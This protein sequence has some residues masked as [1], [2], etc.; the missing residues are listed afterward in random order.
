LHHA[1]HVSNGVGRDEQVDVVGHQHVGVNGATVLQRRLAQIDPVVTVVHLGKE[2]GKPVVAALHGVLGDTRVS[3][4]VGGAWHDESG[5]FHPTGALRKFGA[6]SLDS[7]FASACAGFVSRK[8][9]LTPMALALAW[10]SPR[11]RRSSVFT[12]SGN[13]HRRWIPAFAGMTKNVG[14]ALK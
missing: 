7:P 14:L 8:I 13:D 5:Y 2:A 1:R 9:T 11:K 4:V 10:S 12:S 3:G 6:V